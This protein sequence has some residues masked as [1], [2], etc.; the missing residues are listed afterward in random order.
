MPDKLVDR[1]YYTVPFHYAVFFLLQTVV[2]ILK[3]LLARH[4]APFFAL[5]EEHLLIE[6]SSY[7]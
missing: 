2:F 6:C 7:N 4:I 1:M 5:L 3:Y